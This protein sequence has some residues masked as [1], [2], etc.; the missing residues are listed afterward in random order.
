MY[1]IQEL[2]QKINDTFATENFLFEPVALYEPIAY[3]LAQ[4]GKRIRPL[5][6]LMSADLF[7][8]DIEQAVKPS[9]GVE[10]FHNFTLLHDDIARS[11]RREGSGDHQI[12]TLDSGCLYRQLQSA[13]Q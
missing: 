13:L 9:I 5:L 4:G 10:L 3:A 6:V 12:S 11:L 2:Q 8:A 7:G 1:T